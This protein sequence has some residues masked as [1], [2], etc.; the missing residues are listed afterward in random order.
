MGQEEFTRKWVKFMGKDKLQSLQDALAA[1]V[2]MSVCL[3]DLQGRALTV[4][5]KPL[6]LCHQVRKS[7]REL[8]KKEF[9]VALEKCK[10]ELAPCIHECYFG[11]KYFLYPVLS[12]GK[13]V[14]IV[15]CGGYYEGKN[16]LPERLAAKFAV[17]VLQ[18]EQVEK[19]YQLLLQILNIMDFDVDIA[20]WQNDTDTPE[21]PAKADTYALEFFEGKL[22]KRECDV[23]MLV[24]EGISNKLIAERLYISEKTVKTHISNILNKLDVKDRMQIMMLARK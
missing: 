10:T 3:L 23:A 8:C 19:I 16:I 24:C 4:R 17:P 9:L 7:K 2:D 12:N 21:T 6:L 18:N 5:S 14:A 20:T 13:L 22:S 1:A 15:H 11:L